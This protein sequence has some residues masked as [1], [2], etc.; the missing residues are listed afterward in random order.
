M[1]EDREVL[2]GGSRSPRSRSAL[3]G[4]VKASRSNRGGRPPKFNEPSRPITVTLPQ[5]TLEQLEILGNDRAKAIA[6][7]VKRAVVGPSSK[8]V[9]AE[10][11]PIG[12]GAGLIVVGP[13]RHLKAMN[14]LRIVEIVPGRSI[15]SVR[16]GTSPEFL[17]VALTDMLEAVP[18]TEASER[19]LLLRLL[20]ILRSARKTHR[21]TKEEILIIGMD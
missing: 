21:M 17:E 1:P 19:S 14:C 11:V 9:E 5:S 3:S 13:S 10:I 20:G 6:E 15:L 12:Q 16:I 8:A 4:A 7:A 2:Q 18:E